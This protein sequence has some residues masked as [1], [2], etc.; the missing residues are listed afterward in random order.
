M[1]VSSLGSAERILSRTANNIRLPLVNYAVK[2]EKRISIVKRIKSDIP[3]RKPRCIF[4]A[5]LF[6]NAANGA[7]KLAR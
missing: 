1:C 6:T 4:C 7:K 3:I 5:V 2:P